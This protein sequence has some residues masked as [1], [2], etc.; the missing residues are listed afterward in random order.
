M[1]VEAIFRSFGRT[2]VLV[3][4]DVILDEYITG[5]VNRM[6]PEAPVPLLRREA[7][8]FHLGGAANVAHSIKQLGAEPILCSVVGQDDAG[9]QIRG[10]L[11]AA[12]IST[13]T[14]LEDSTYVTSLK[15]RFLS[16]GHHLLRMDRELDEPI[17]PAVAEALVVAATAQVAACD[18]VL[19]QDYDKGVLS[20]AVIE[21]IIGAAKKRGCPVVVDP[22]HRNFFAY[23]GATLFK[24]NLR[25]LCEALRISPT[26]TDIKAL[27][28]AAQQL[29]ARLQLEQVMVTLSAEGI[30]LQEAA[31][32][33]LVPSIVRHVV[34]VSGAGDAVISVVSLCCACQVNPVDMVLMANVAGGWV[35]EQTG[36]AAIDHATLQALVQ[37]RL[38]SLSPTQYQL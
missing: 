38:T 11:E 25:E 34:D 2:R 6:S 28:A 3:V 17:A 4:G 9:Q 5:V 18:V 13:D 21:A 15:T 19:F 14:L 8:T 32:E 30:F 35:C 37:T 16:K 31:A 26:G 23:E 7:Q 20:P 10:L 12:Q 22:K 33:W 29:R 1:D 27:S 36:V 24:P